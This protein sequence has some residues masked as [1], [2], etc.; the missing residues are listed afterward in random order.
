MKKPHSPQQLYNASPHHAELLAAKLRWVIRIVS[1][2]LVIFFTWLQIRDVEIASI[3]ERTS[4]QILL[5]IALIAYYFCWVF[6][7]TFDL[8]LMQSVLTKVPDRGRLTWG[9]VSAL[10]VFTA[11]TFILLWASND[12]KRFAYALCLFWTA[13]TCSFW[14][15]QRTIKP[16]FSESG[17]DCRNTYDHER[18][19]TVENFMLGEWQWTRNAF[20]LFSY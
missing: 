13:G 11:F 14:Y 7:T 8:N 16:M 18:L 15:L 6:G 17:A 5:R 9:A 12:E 3:I 10:V 1:I 4:P 2:L 20:R 19:L